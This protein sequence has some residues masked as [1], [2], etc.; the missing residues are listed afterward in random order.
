MNEQ[1]VDV[2]WTNR[3]AFLHTLGL[4]VGSTLWASRAAQAEGTTWPK[5]GVDDEGAS[6]S[7]DAIPM[8]DVSTQRLPGSSSTDGMVS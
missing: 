1:K 2:S 4:G 5:A 6:T 7:A 3:R 8:I